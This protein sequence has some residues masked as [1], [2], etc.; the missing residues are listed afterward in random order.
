M[1]VFVREVTTHKRHIVGKLQ[2]QEGDRQEG[3]R[4]ILALYQ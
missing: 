1:P 4:P 3:V 2:K